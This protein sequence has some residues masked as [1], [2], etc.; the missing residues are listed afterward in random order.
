MRWRGGELQVADRWFPSSKT[1][2][3]CGA[4]KTKLRLDERVYRCDRCGHRAD[5]DVNAARNLAALASKPQVGSTSS[6]RCG[7]TLNEPDGKPCKPKPVGS[8]YSHGNSLQGE[9][10]AGEIA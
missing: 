9:N 7:A 8:G 1:C 3:R 2:G 5:R 10:V 4:V 6:S